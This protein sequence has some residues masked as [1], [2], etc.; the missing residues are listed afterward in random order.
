[1]SLAIWIYLFTILIRDK[2]GV[3]NYSGQEE[4]SKA[5]QGESK[6]PLSFAFQR[7]S[8]FGSEESTLHLANVERPSLQR[9]RT[10]TTSSGR[11]GDFEVSAM[12][13]RGLSKDGQRQCHLLPWLWSAL[14]RVCGPY[15]ARSCAQGLQ[16]TVCTGARPRAILGKDG[17]HGFQKTL[18][19]EKLVTKE[20]AKEKAKNIPRDRQRVRSNP[21]PRAIWANRGW[22]MQPPPPFNDP[23]TAAGP[24]TSPQAETK[25]VRR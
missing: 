6:T 9:S 17:N 12:E 20:K 21:K 8:R 2:E 18:Y 23:N 13:M 25:L 10:L 3:Q 16:G 4:I 14:G 1:M 22:R 24:D 15:P 7:G 11:H 5:R 19:M